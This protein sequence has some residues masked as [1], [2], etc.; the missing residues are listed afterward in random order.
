MK[1]KTDQVG[2]A[3]EAFVSAEILRRGGYAATFSGNMPG[4]DILASDADHGHQITIQVK[5]RTGGDWQ[6]TPR[7]GQR[8]TKDPHD[9]RFWVLVDLAPEHPD[10]YV[11]PA[12]WIENDIFKTHAAFVARHGG[13]ES[14][15]H[16][17]THHKITTTRV[18]KWQDRWDILGIVSE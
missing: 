8:H 2:R 3:G 4:I 6:T 17:W 15:E 10:Y 12:Y 16:E 7:R 11:M 1:L 5:T 14:F 18:K 9:N 13:P